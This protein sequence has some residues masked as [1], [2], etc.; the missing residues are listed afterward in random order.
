VPDGRIA[1]RGSV[2]QP[3]RMRTRP[4]DLLRILALAVVY[5]AAARLGLAFDAFAGFA[6]LVW[7]PTGIALAALLLFGYR[8]WP[9]V[10]LG[11]VI[12]NSMIA[13]AS[14]SVAIGI[15]IGNT[16]EALVGVYILRHTPGFHQTLETVRAA[17]GLL[18][19][20]VFSTLIGASIGVVCL[21]A[22]GLIT[23]AQIGEAWRSWWIGDMVG[24]LLVAPV[25]LVWSERPRVRFHPPRAETV[26]LTVAL[27]VVTWVTFFGDHTRFPLLTRFHATNALLATFIWAAL[28]FGQRGSVT[29]AFVVS[30]AA[31]AGTVLG[32]GQ[33]TAPDVAVRLL[34]LQTF[35]AS[36]VSIFLLLGAT[37]SE[38]RGAYDEASRAQREAADANLVKSE[39]LAIMSH[40][41]RTP[42]NAIAGYAELLETGVYGPLSDKQQGVVGRIHRNEREL[43]SQLDEVFGFVR[44]EK[45]EVHVQS[46]NI[47]VVDAFDAVEPFVRPEAER[48]RLTF[49]R[50]LSR[51]RLAVLADPKGLQQIL[52]SLLSNASKFTADGGEITLGAEP[53]GKTVR[54]WVRDTGVGISQD[55]IQRVFEPFVQAERAST[56]RSSGVGLGL[57]IAR[58]LARRMSGE[59]TIASEVGAGTTASVLLPAA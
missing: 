49:R 31:I 35:T 11:A 48:K 13:H 1:P 9:G 40:E 14:L 21:D 52:T 7:P 22:G 44:A 47:Q 50:A 20:A 16:L 26:G 19:V 15:G 39:F 2:R 58:D 10:F 8:L 18:V 24:A 41:L 37:V 57:T 25:I 3:P 56:R 32:L 51:P 33:F 5:A 45:G 36:A 28:R 54:I 46:Q 17:V 23:T 30:S 55:Q 38:R 42:L 43:L 12:A 53:D 59:L 29:A 34:S 4:T 6:A 27:V